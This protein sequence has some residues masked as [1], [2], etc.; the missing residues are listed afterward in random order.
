MFTSTFEQELKAMN[1]VRIARELRPL[2]A[3]FF[4]QWF[5][6]PPSESHVAKLCREWLSDHSISFRGNA[7]L[8]EECRAL[9][10][11]DRSK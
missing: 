5:G 2:P 9:N 7:A 1:N 11:L 4:A 6:R 3:E 10:A 8:D